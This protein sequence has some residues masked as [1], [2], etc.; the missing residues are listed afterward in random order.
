L[1]DPDWRAAWI[2]RASVG[3]PEEYTFARTKVSLKAVAIDRA[4]AYMSASQQA[5]LWINGTRVAQ[6]PSFAY[7][8]DGYY[9]STDVTQTLRSGV[10]N[11][12]GALYHWSGAGKGRPASE[13]GV[14]VQVVILPTESLPVLVNH[15]APSGPTVM[16]LGLLIV[17]LL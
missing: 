10:A 11:A 1:H 13:P 15:S 3:E 4:V 2:R 16:L 9:L 12:I 7:P 14:I 6:G 8:D 5:E 17:E